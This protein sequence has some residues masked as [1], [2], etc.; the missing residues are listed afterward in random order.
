MRGEMFYSNTVQKEKAHN[1]PPSEAIVIKAGVTLNEKE[2][3]MTGGAFRKDN[4][5][6]TVEYEANSRY[7]IFNKNFQKD[8][9]TGKLIEPRDY[10]ME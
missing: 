8:K 9:I 5:M 7:S 4:R 3:Q 2:K 6:S 1:V 10:Y